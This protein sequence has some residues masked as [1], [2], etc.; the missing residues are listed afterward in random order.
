M[1]IAETP[2]AIYVGHHKIREGIEHLQFLGVPVK[3]LELII[4]MDVFDS[5]DTLS[6]Y[7]NENDQTVW[8]LVSHS[9]EI[10]CKR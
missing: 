6:L 10:R 8:V 2:Y 4:A 9:Y 5:S 3:V 1:A 7:R